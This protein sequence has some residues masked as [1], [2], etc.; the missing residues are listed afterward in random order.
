MLIWIRFRFVSFFLMVY[1]CV[2]NSQRK[3]VKID[4]RLKALIDI[5]N[6]IPTNVVDHVILTLEVVRGKK[7]SKEV[8]FGYHSQGCNVLWTCS[9]DTPKYY[10]LLF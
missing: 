2:N 10:R 8:K 1:R 9:Y 4:N 5:N 6:M 7:W 3:L